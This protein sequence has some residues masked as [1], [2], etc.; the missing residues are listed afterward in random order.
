MDNHLE[1][2]TGHGQND[3]FQPIV[4]SVSRTMNLPASV[5][6]L[7]E[8]RQGLRI[9]AA[10]GL[11]LSYVREAFLALDEKSVTGEA[12]KTEQITVVRDILSDP[13]W[14]Y[15][16]Q[17]REMGWKSALCVPIRVH[18]SVIGVI[19]IYT[20][21][22]RDFSDLEK[23]LLANY[24]AQVELTIEADR[25]RATLDRLLEAGHQIERLI[26]EQPKVV[27]EEI[28]KAACQVIGADC[29]VL[30]PY[31]PYREDFYDVDSV[32]AYGLSKPLQISERPRRQTGMAA[33]VK[34]EGEVVISDIEAEDPDMLS[35]PFIKREGVKAFMG[36]ALQVATDVLGIL[37]VDFRAPHPFSEEEKDTIRLFAHQAALAIHNSRSYQQA[38]SRAEALK[39]LHETGSALVSISGVPESLEGVLTKIAQSAQSVLG[40]DLVD[41]YQ[42]VQSRDEYILPAVQVGERYH[43]SVRKT[44]TYRDDVVCAIVESRQPLYVIESQQDPILNKPFTAVSPESPLPRFVIREDIRST[45]AVPL[46]VGTEVV[47]VLF[48]NY[49]SPQTFPQQQRELIELFASQASVAIH[50]AR[51]YSDSLRKSQEL[52]TIV[53]I[54]KLLMS[55]LE[56]A[57][58]LKRLMQQVVR[59]FGVEG[60][61]LWR[62]D[63]RTEIVEPVFVLDRTGQEE[64]L[65]R[66]IKK[67]P[68]GSFHFGKGIVGAVAKTGT[69]MIVND[70]K[71]EPQWDS[72]VDAITGFITK[73][74]LAVPL[75][76]R[77][78]VVGII[79]VLN[80]LDGTPFTV[81]D[82]ELLTAI[83]SSAAIAL[84]NAR[85]YERKIR[86]VNTLTELGQELAFRAMPVEGT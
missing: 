11:P 81:R 43:P 39:M 49:R 37:Y 61:S 56:M 52:Q 63:E 14:K 5:W 75:V 53:E 29:A 65:S 8:Q 22:V 9:A 77:Q 51:L 50:N 28:V 17:A 36:I 47:G 45:A 6:V 78:E 57:E 76:Y 74:I 18:G 54:G 71:T 85:L 10:V 72:S 48:A 3:S 7:D 38:E 62:A 66:P 24:A 73:S 12:Y 64:V 70:V 59:L 31:D 46:V 32:V 41:I 83:A 34:R 84:E 26:T 67:M 33:Y 16:D 80:R 27:L 68:P 86:E 4:E 21:V 40:A 15:K 44:K 35:S 1:I 69:P 58:V 13:R 79:E 55:T 20:F 19:S 42:Y 82:Q 30:Y 60:A 25:R 23:E 2:E